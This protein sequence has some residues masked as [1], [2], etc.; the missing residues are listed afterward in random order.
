MKKS[1]RKAISK[2]WGY[3]LLPILAWAWLVAHL[4]PSP[5]AL[6][7]TL[8]V[9]FFLFQAPVPCCAETRKGEWCRN[10]A[11]GILGGCHFKQHRWQNAKMFFNRE[12]RQKV[13]NGVLRGISGKAA[14]V[15]AVIAFG[16][17][18]V[19]LGTLLVNIAKS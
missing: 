5:I 14:T 2:S 3:V 10:N 12:T 7:S 17:L 18:L 4:G 9:G 13:A 6:M 11:S 8:A 1:T 19:S 15:S 16:A